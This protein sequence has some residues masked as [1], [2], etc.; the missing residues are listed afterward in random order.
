MRFV[1][2]NRMDLKPPKLTKYQE[3]LIRKDKE[4][5]RKRKEFF[6][7]I[8]K[9]LKQPLFRKGRRTKTRNGGLNVS[10]SAGIQGFFR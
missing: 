2:D 10:A 1:D 4:K 9:R 7:K 5:D 3:E 8:G 6:Q